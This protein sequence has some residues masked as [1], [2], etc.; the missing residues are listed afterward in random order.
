MSSSSDEDESE[1][2]YES[3]YN[4]DDWI[5]FLND[6]SK[7]Y[8][9]NEEYDTEDET[10]NI[11]KSKDWE[12]FL[13]DNTLCSTFDSLISLEIDDEKT[14]DNSEDDD[15]QDEIE[16]AV[17]SET[18]SFSNIKDEDE[19]EDWILFSDD[20]LKS[21]TTAT[22]INDD[23]LFSIYTSTLSTRSVHFNLNI[24]QYYDFE[25]EIEC[26]DY[27]AFAYSLPVWEISRRDMFRK[28]NAVFNL[29]QEHYNIRQ[30]KNYKF[31]CTIFD[32]KSKLTVYFNVMSKL[33]IN[34]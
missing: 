15:I 26:T 20:E 6:N 31:R 17:N 16:D 28:K 18:L 12:S 5:L 33:K 1:E 9:T 19:I 10:K 14:N 21:D 25:T 7:Y 8:D 27:L 32:I 3:K 30:Q 11:V 29:I 22:I 23:T 2:E 4:C 13:N 24:T 34:I